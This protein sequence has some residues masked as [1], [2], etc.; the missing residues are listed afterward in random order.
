MHA[1]PLSQANK[2]TGPYYNFLT[3]PFLSFPLSTLNIPCWTFHPGQT[4][5]HSSTHSIPR[6]VQYSKFCEAFIRSPTAINVPQGP[7]KLIKPSLRNRT[8]F[9]E[10]PFSLLGRYPI[11]KWNLWLNG[12][13]AETTTTA[14]AAGTSHRFQSLR[15]NEARVDA[16]SSHKLSLSRDIHSNSNN[17]NKYKSFHYHQRPLN[18][19]QNRADRP[20]SSVLQSRSYFHKL[21]FIRC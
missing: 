12:P 6:C 1:H 17:F 3:M 18:E 11:G 9:R 14:T 19:P 5:T 8:N 15:M 21:H 13:E 16:W 10:S 4:S 7:I 20:L 2:R